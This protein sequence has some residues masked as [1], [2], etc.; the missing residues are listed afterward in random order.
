MNDTFRSYT[1]MDE[2]KLARAAWEGLGNGYC[3]KGG[4]NSLLVGGVNLQ[5]RLQQTVS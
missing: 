1:A 3:T 5:R 4:F 2:K